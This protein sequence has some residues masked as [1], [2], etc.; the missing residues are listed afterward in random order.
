MYGSPVPVYRIYTCIHI[1]HTHV[2]IC[3]FA[4]FQKCCSRLG[5]VYIF[6]TTINAIGSARP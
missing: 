1:S 2:Y 6:I 4:F 3:K 5:A